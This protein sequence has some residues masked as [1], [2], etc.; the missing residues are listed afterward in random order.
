MDF[1]PGRGRRLL[2]KREDDP[3]DT[4]AGA[5]GQRKVGVYDTDTPA[6]KT[7]SKSVPWLGIAAAV[8]AFIIILI[9]LF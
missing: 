8:I 7:G 9:L 6:G 5:T 1:N 3:A 2:I 4:S